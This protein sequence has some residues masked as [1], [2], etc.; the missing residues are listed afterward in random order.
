MSSFHRNSLIGKA[1]ISDKWQLAYVKHAGMWAPQD[2]PALYGNWKEEEDKE[3]RLCFTRTDTMHLKII[4][5]TPEGLILVFS[6]YSDLRG[7]RLFHL[8]NGGVSLTTERHLDFSTDIQ[9]KHI[10]LSIRS[11]VRGQ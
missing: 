11:V 3:S 5:Y 8:A 9:I 10:F 7:I 4:V 2:L 1:R 6:C